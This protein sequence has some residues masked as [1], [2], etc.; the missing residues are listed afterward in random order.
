MGHL[1]IQELHRYSGRENLTVAE[2]SLLNGA[3][4]VTGLDISVHVQALLDGF[5]AGFYFLVWKV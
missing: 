5:S 2:A 3:S 1:F 4:L